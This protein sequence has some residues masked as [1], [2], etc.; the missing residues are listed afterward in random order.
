M[1]LNILKQQGKISFKTEGWWTWTPDSY[2]TKSLNCVGV[3]WVSKWLFLGRL[4]ICFFLFMVRMLQW[5]CW[6]GHT[7]GGGFP[8]KE[9]LLHLCSSMLRLREEASQS[10]CFTSCSIQS[11]KSHS[12]QQKTR[13]LLWISLLNR[14]TLVN[15]GQWNLR[16]LTMKVHLNNTLIVYVSGS[17]QVYEAVVCC[18]T[19]RFSG[20]SDHHWPCHLQADMQWTKI[21]MKQKSLLLQ[22]LQCAEKTAQ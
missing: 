8:R 21:F 13:V 4:I 20:D 12:W 15:C 6:S 17:S 5:G 2:V 1:F 3:I 19:F 22:A 9:V 14:F 10:S 18:Q 7:V 11:K 16:T